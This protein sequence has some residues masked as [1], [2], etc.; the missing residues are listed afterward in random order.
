M[1]HQVTMN[2]TQPP[3]MIRLLM[4]ITGI[5]EVVVIPGELLLERFREPFM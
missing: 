5:I 1:Y 2:L 3:A 4:T